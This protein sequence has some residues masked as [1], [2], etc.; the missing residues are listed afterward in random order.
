VHGRDQQV[1]QGVGDFPLPFVDERGQQGQHQRPGMV[2]E[3]RR[4]FHCGAGPP[5]GD[6]PRRD[7]GEQAVRQSGSANRIQLADLGQHGLQAHV[8]GNR[9]DQRQRRRLCAVGLIVGDLGQGGQAGAG[10][11][12]EP[13][14][15]QRRQRLLG[16][17]Q[18]RA[19]DPVAAACGRRLDPLRA[20]ASQQFLPDPVGA[21]LGPADAVGQPSGELAGVLGGAFAEPQVAADLRP[22]VFDCA[23]RPFVEPEVGCWHADLAGDERHR[24]VV[25]LGAAARE[26]A[27]LGIELQHQSEAQPGRPA[28]PRDELPLVIQQSPVLDQL[29]Q[30]HPHH[31]ALI[32]RG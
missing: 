18:G 2:A 24:L 13:R 3:V 11:R 21:P 15:H 28:L 4:R 1:R 10:V 27:R 23:A 26:P 7:A 22:V 17:V 12:A 25:Q 32:V 19:D 5:G 29:V 31:R 8:A 6:H 14:G 16:L 9:L 30:V 20:A